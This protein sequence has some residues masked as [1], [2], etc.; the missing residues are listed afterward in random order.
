[1]DEINV[2]E[3]LDHVENLKHQE[4]G[5]VVAETAFVHFIA[6]VKQIDFSSF[7][8]NEVETIIEVVH[9]VL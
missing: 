8:H 4:F 3:C 2:I 5:G 1:V 9:A 6:V 7:L